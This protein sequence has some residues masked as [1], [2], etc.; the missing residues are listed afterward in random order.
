M[1][2][3]SLLTAAHT[4]RPLNPHRKERK[5]IVSNLIDNSEIKIIIS[6]MHALNVPIR[7]NE[8][9]AINENEETGYA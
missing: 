9:D 7:H 2:G 8:T 1:L 4:K 3:F 6:V 5:K